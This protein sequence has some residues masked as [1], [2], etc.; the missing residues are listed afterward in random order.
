MRLVIPTS[1][2][3]IT[4]LNVQHYDIMCAII[5]LRGFSV[6]KYSELR[7]V[8]DS[9]D[10]NALRNFIADNQ[11]L[12]YDNISPNGASILW[13]ALMPTEEKDISLD[14][15][16]MLLN[17]I[18]ADGNA[19]CNPTQPFA[20][21]NRPID[22]I[23]NGVQVALEPLEEA[24][25]RAENNYVAPVHA[26]N[27]L[28]DLAAI[29]NDDQSAHNPLITLVVHA[30]VARLHQHYSHDKGIALDGE[31]VAASKK[32]ISDFAKVCADFSK[33]KAVQIQSG[34][35]FCFTNSSKFTVHPNEN[36]SQAE[37][38]LSLGEL[39]TLVWLAAK[40]DDA[41]LL[42]KN[43][44]VAET[45]ETE[46]A[47]QSRK[48]AILECFCEIATAYGAYGMSC[49]S[50]AFTRLGMILA[51]QHNLVLSFDKTKPITGPQARQ[52]IFQALG[53]RL[54]N[55][56]QEN[57]AQ[58]LSVIRYLAL[59]KSDSNDAKEYQL[60]INTIKPLVSAELSKM[61]IDGK[62]I[63]NNL[64]VIDNGED[65]DYP[66][67]GS[68]KSIYLKELMVFFE[69][70]NI[71][72]EY[73][74][75]KMPVD[76]LI[77]G[78]IKQVSQNLM[79]YQPFIDWLQQYNIIL[80][81]KS[82]A[83]FISGFIST[84]LE[85]NRLQDEVLSLTTFTN[86]NSE[87]YFDKATP[88]KQKITACAQPI[89]LL[90]LFNFKKSTLIDNN[91]EQEMWLNSLANQ[92]IITLMS[93]VYG[94]NKAQCAKNDFNLAQAMVLEALE[95]GITANLSLGNVRFKNQDLRA[96]DFSNTDL[97][98]VTFEQCMLPIAGSNITCSKVTLIDCCLPN[99]INNTLKKNILFSLFKIYCAFSQSALALQFY[100]QDLDEVFL[101]Q[102]TKDGDSALMIAAC[103][104][105]IEC[106]K[107]LLASE[108]CSK[109]VFNAKDEYD[110]NAL[111]LAARLGKTECL[112]V[113]LASEH[114]SKEAF[115]AI[116]KYGNNALM[117]SAGL[118]KTECLK[119]LLASEHCSK[120]AFNAI[121]KYGNNALMISAR[122]GETECLKALLASE[123]CSKE[124]FNAIDKDGSNA[125][126]LA[127]GL[128]KT[129]CLKSLLASEHCSKEAFNATNKDGNNALMISARLGETECLKTLLA[130]E[131]CSKE[132]FNAIDK[133]GNSALLLAAK[134]GKTEFL[135]ALL[136]SEHCSKE[137]FNAT[138]K[139]GNN[140]LL[141]AAGSGNE[142]HNMLLASEH[143]SEDAFNAKEEDGQDYSMLAAKKKEAE[144]LAPSVSE[145]HSKAAMKNNHSP[146]SMMV[147]GGFISALGV[148]AVALA[149]I[150]LNA[151]TF[152]IAGVA[153]TA[154][155]AAA[156][157]AGVGVFAVGAYK[158]KGKPDEP[159]PLSG[160]PAFD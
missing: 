153:M 32:E 89:V 144:C 130:S 9:Q 29:A 121:D 2:S 65:S 36:T 156:A 160:C 140:A 20:G 8:V 95:Q 69:K 31:L 75:E 131:H 50:G 27:P 92:D 7:G 70:N 120:E 77:D 157:L 14:L 117:I 73:F 23:E 154:T 104:E 132:A 10:I 83:S 129:E 116:D 37:I 78:A 96:F 68:K 82:D 119:V 58:Y 16:E 47:L 17:Y 99:G 42:P 149:F 66:L 115:N 52:V 4:L 114:C 133:Y 112:K 148:A 127:A 26:A 67:S 60:F 30:N 88:E 90:A 11:A 146:I 137:A 151:S 84:W 48:K 38:A 34:L 122:L 35:N 45:N 158:S 124:A 71:P 64:S 63:E 21:Y 142:C 136:A 41:S 91:P 105:S 98:K 44:E 62:E 43:N 86:P 107:T 12:N 109:E 111:M 103:K 118:G 135:K 3:L 80:E 94:K 39:A 102:K 128:G 125:L 59:E 147:L 56:L 54:D 55:L 6:D 15:V 46:S 5:I 81:D 110:N 1:K 101:S 61:N 93:A 97:N 24:L 18:K 85:Q 25:R 138:N 40:E 53:A 51:A 49:E 123:H 152:G 28:Q 155:G 13:W 139:D 145:R 134:L 108:H 150:A 106:L 57:E 126:M 19:L 87:F 159:E 100:L 76:A 79:A 22:Y 113:L 143:Y 141:L 33:E 72:S 74:Y